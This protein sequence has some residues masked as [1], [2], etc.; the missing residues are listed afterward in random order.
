MMMGG[1]HI[2]LS[3]LKVMG[4][5]LGGSGWTTVMATANVTTEGRADSIQKGDTL[6]QSTMGSSGDGCGSVCVANACSRG[7]SG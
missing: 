5:W 7:I 6:F 1:L 3:M 4:D 2:E